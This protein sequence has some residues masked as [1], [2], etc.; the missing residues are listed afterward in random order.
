V[1]FGENNKKT[2]VE[3][4]WLPGADSSAELIFAGSEKKISKP[5]AGL[6]RR[7]QLYC[8]TEVGFDRP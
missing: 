6:E 5:I 1:G 8:R 7:L 2:I 4:S 3:S